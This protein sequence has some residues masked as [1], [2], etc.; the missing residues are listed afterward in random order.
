[1]YIYGR[2]TTLLLPSSLLSGYRRVPYIVRRFLH[3]SPK[4]PL[5]PHM[6]PEQSKRELCSLCDFQLPFINLAQ[7]GAFSPLFVS[8]LLILWY[9]LHPFPFFRSMLATGSLH[10]PPPKP[11]AE[12]RIPRR[13]SDESSSACAS[14][15]K[16]IALS[17]WNASSCL[18]VVQVGHSV[19]RPQS[20]LVTWHC[21]TLYFRA[22]GFDIS[23]Y[24]MTENEKLPRITADFIRLIPWDPESLAHVERLRQQRIACGWK[25]NLVKKWRSLHREGKVGMHWIVSPWRE[26]SCLETISSI[27]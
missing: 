17:D 13:P 19:S 27:I 14:S 3:A 15:L 7:K 24:K 5:A 23:L 12:L 16:P 10:G 26:G 1:M 2:L 20:E 4:W 8:W 11:E 9:Q 18:K 21:C 22:F 6:A 25:E